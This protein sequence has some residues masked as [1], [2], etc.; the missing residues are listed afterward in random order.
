MHSPV[1]GRLKN[2]QNCVS[3]CDGS[4]ITNYNAKFQKWQFLYELKLVNISYSSLNLSILSSIRN[5]R[6]DVE[7]A[8]TDFEN[9]SFLTGLETITSKHSYLSKMTMLNIHDNPKMKRF[10]MYSL[11]VGFYSRSAQK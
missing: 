7:I 10:G 9:L 6:G 8:A 11:K 3:A 5:V 4:K 2:C 1:V